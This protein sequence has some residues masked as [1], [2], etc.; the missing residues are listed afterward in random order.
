M[1]GTVALHLPTPHGET[2]PLLG[3]QASFPRSNTS[4]GRHR[5]QKSTSSSESS[6]SSFNSG[7][8]DFIARR[9][10]EDGVLPETAVLGRTLG[11][12]SAYILIISRVIGSGIFA[13]PGA[14]VSSVGSIGL[15]LTLWVAGAI[16]SW[17]GLAVGLEYGCMLPRSGGDKVYLEFTYR[18]PRFLASTIVA[19][20]AVLL[21]FTASNCIVFGEYILF[22][23]G[24]H[25]S[26]H[27]VEVRT[28]AVTLMTLITI[29]HGC[30]LRT[31]IFIQNLLGWIKV[32]LILFMTLASAVVVL[33]GYRPT[34]PTEPT[35]LLPSWDAIWEGSVWN[36]GIISTALFK[37]FYSY[38]GL[39]NVNN[40][41]NEVRDPVKTLRSAAPTALFT[42]CLLYF[43]V[44]V[45]YFLIVPLNEIKKSGELIAALFFQRLLGE[46]TGRIF[47][48][49]A[50][51]ISAAGNVMV[52][53]FSLARLNQE[54]ARQGLLPCG[55]LWSSSRPFGAPLGALLV[56]YVPSVVVICVPAKNIYSFIL[57]VEGYPGQFFV[58][59]TSLGLIWL[60]KTR[61]DLNRPY[62]AFLSAVWARIALSLAMIAAPFIPTV[63]ESHRD[64]LF[65]A[66]Y[67]LVGISV[68]VFAVLYWSVL[69]VILPRLG[70]YRLDEATEV[71]QDG[72]VI[73]KLIH[74]PR[75]ENE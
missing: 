52:V 11:W 39:Q 48:P 28:L 7:D 18:H 6:A 26:E 69:A 14:I 9:D 37:V 13:T 8:V 62:K 35:R 42:T 5:R 63:G 66:S 25:P 20:H 22:A 27:R 23:L 49:L 65:R 2:T 16:I 38:S 47:L 24:K 55:H 67:A 34:A 56:H 46:T 10:I 45:A 71:L 40:V 17:F 72:T 68:L 51:A 75:G 44:N 12:K 58:L 31:G 30:F 41:L 1:T 74:I 73:T 15:S 61:P 33:A 60:R 3:T 59:A 53:T 54:I 21:G 64:H 29:I 4:Q 57:D 36:W 19:V 32:G 43:L 70:R 50:V